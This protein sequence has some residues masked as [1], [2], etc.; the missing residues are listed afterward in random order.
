MNIS[1]CCRKLPPV[2]LLLA[3]LLTLGCSSMK[4]SSLGDSSDQ[5]YGE[6]SAEYYYGSFEDVPI[7]VQMKATQDGYIVY[8]QG[9]V[10]VGLETFTGW[11]NVNSLNQAMR[12]YMARD[13][14]SLYAASRGAKQTVQI[15]VKDSMLSV[16]I[17]NDNT[18]GTEMLVY[19][20]QKI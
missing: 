10:K 5:A 16:I 9:N 7:P 14:W 6:P 20:T 4:N 8:T 3:L 11:V 19:V 13:G 15:F 18:F 12:D 17:T 2:C 1:A